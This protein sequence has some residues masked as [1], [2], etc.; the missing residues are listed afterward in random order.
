M[1]L[2]E[3]VL[4]SCLER[5]SSVLVFYSRALFLFNLGGWT[6]FSRFLKKDPSS[7]HLSVTAATACNSCNSSVTAVTA[8]QL[9]LSV[10]DAAVKSDSYWEIFLTT[11]PTYSQ[12]LLRDGF[13]QLTND[14]GFTQFRFYCFKRIR[15]RVFDIREL[16]WWSFL[17][18]LTM[19]LTGLVTLSHASQM[20]TQLWP[21]D[22]VTGVLRQQIDGD[23]K[24][25]LIKNASIQ[26]QFCGYLETLLHS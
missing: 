1:L 10:Q 11:T 15:E 20:T 23:M 12:L 4:P 14:I 8:W 24:I 16:T 6:L 17:P 9:H 18:S 13:N 22:V 19:S 5:I 21:M 25:T 26:G 7:S 3:V 2:N